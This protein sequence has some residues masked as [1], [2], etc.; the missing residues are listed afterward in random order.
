M[1]EIG[2]AVGRVA[3]VCYMELALTIIFFWV[4]GFITGYVLRD[5]HRGK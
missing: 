1:Y 3:A 4:V 2:Y 5:K